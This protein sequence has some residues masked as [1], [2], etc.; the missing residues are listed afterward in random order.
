MARKTFITNNYLMFLFQ[1]H[2]IY[3]R[4]NNERQ[5]IGMLELFKIPMSNHSLNSKWN[6]VVCRGI[7]S[8]KEIRMCINGRK[9][10]V[11]GFEVNLTRYLVS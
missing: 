8:C 2:Q 9:K 4:I 3:H 11:L 1:S 7:Y 6:Q 10:C 5:R